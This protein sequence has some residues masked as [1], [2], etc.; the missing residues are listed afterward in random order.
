MFSTP[1]IIPSE[2][3][4]IWF[5]LAHF[6]SGTHVSTLSVLV[7]VLFVRQAAFRYTR[8]VLGHFGYDWYNRYVWCTIAF[9]Y[10]EDRI[11]V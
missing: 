7:V 8:I 3:W 5:T 6:T 4:Y 10:P 1:G 11:S 9:Y 2:F